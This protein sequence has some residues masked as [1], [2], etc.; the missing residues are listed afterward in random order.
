MRQAVT[1][2][3]KLGAKGIRILSS[4]RLNGSEMARKEGDRLG[5]IP[6]HTLRADIDYG[7][8]EAPT[9]YGNIGVKVWI[10]RGEVLP[11]QMVKEPE[12]AKNTGNDRFQK[13][14]PGGRSDHTTDRRPRNAE[15]VKVA[16]PVAGGD[17]EGGK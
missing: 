8:A 12:A 3:M 14:R 5:K 16:A 1:R 15:A 6:L 9:T 2:A 10:C 17:V 7:F 11:G 13:R 4:G